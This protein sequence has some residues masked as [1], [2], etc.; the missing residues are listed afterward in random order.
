MYVSKRAEI[1]FLICHNMEEKR[2]YNWFKHLILLGAKWLTLHF[3]PV[4]GQ[5]LSCRNGPFASETNLQICSS[6]YCYYVVHLANRENVQALLWDN[7]SL[8][9]QKTRL[10]LSSWQLGKP[11][12]I[13]RITSST[14]S[15]TN[16]QIKAVSKNKPKVW[17]LL[18]CP[19]TLL[20]FIITTA[21]CVLSMWNPICTT[22]MIW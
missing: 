9:Y 8:S 4:Q 6:G 5:L 17:M 14:K 12:F 18:H 3:P 15:L 22:W 13:M 16:S 11:I 19:Q 2:W 21:H 1:I 10:L 20:M 7:I